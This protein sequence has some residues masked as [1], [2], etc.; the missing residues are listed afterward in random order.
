MKT[1]L[2]RKT[3]IVIYAADDCDPNVC[4][5]FV[6]CNYRLRN[7]KK[8]HQIDTCAIITD[9]S[10]TCLNLND[11][12]FNMMESKKKL[13]DFTKINILLVNYNSAHFIYKI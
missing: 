2:K 7:R 9:K 8:S 4:R 5:K 1:K 6:G 11:C 3:S 13:I 12:E 10:D